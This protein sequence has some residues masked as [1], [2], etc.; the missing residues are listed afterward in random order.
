MQLV[1]RALTAMAF[2]LG[3]LPAASASPAAEREVLRTVQTLVEAWREADVAK[4]A[5]VLHPDFRIT[6]LQGAENARHIFLDTRAGLLAAIGMIKPG[7]WDV[8][9]LHTSVS[10]DPN[11]MANVW[12]KYEFYSDGKLNHCGYESYELFRGRE[13]WKIINFSDTDTAVR[14][15]DRA[16]VC[17]D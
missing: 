9:L 11:G 17:P 8:H 4:G 6:S 13:G 2:L 12:A 1:T 10:I 14:G 3:A 15:R 5:A 16:S 7:A